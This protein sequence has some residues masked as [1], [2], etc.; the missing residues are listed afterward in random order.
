M[1]RDFINEILSKKGRLA[2]S[3]RFLPVA[4]R[5][6]PLL[7][8]FKLVESYKVGMGELRKYFPIATVA[9]VETYFRLCFRDMIDHGEP[10]SENAKAFKD[11]PFKIESVLAIQAKKVSLGDFVAHLLPV[12]NARNIFENMSILLGKDFEGYLRTATI[13]IPKRGRL[14]IEKIHPGF[15]IDFHKTFELRHIYCHEA[16]PEPFNEEGRVLRCISSSAVVIAATED[17]IS[18]ALQLSRQE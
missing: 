9:C 5:L 7:E 12:K 10:F 14:V 18:G 8:A 6:L 13:E 16:A 4:L 1:K 3:H 17:L 15:L 2:H 11:I